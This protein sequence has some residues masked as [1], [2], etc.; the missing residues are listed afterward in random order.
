MFDFLLVVMLR[1]RL[2]S[3]LGFIVL[4]FSPYRDSSCSPHLIVIHRVRLSEL[5]TSRETR[6]ARVIVAFSL[7]SMFL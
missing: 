6:D 4:A 1:L 5:V 7:C 3:S 2:L